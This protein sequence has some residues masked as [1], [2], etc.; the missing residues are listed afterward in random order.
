M[1]EGRNGAMNAPWLGCWGGRGLIAST[2]VG[3]ND[4][5]NG[6]VGGWCSFFG[7][8]LPLLRL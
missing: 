7:G 2:M 6:M 4:R 5:E 1:T 3:D 8:Y